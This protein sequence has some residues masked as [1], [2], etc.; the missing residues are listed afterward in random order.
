[1]EDCNKV[2]GAL[3]AWAMNQSV[4][5]LQLA[6]EGM[7]KKED[8]AE[9][10]GVIWM[11]FKSLK[12]ATKHCDGLAMTYVPN[13]KENQGKLH[14]MRN[15]KLAV[16]LERYDPAQ[17]FVLV[18]SIDGKKGQGCSWRWSIIH[19]DACNRITKQDLMCAPLLPDKND[20]DENQINVFGGVAACAGPDCQTRAAKMRRCKRCKAVY[21]CSTE[22]QKKHWPQHKNACKA[23]ANIRQAFTAPPPTTTT[24]TNT[25]GDALA[26]ATDKND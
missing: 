15:R 21:Y 20:D 23:M 24:T 26:A 2:I 7:A 6:L 17:H 19:G 3:E 25:D 8:P 11:G 9:R 1:M 5:L 10:R 13:T 4:K 12:Q 18:V 16:V 22:C 14:F